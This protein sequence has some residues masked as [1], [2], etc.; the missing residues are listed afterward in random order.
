ML[1]LRP[2][3][4]R[5]LAIGLLVPVILAL[6]VVQGCSTNSSRLATEDLVLH[7]VA[8]RY[9]DRLVV[10]ATLNPVGDPETRIELSESDRL[11]VRLNDQAGQLSQQWNRVYSHQLQ[12]EEG[13]LTLSLKR[14]NGH[15]QALDTRL[16]LPVSPEFQAPD[17]DAIFQ[18]ARNS[19]IPV[20]WTGM[21]TENGRFDLMCPSARDGLRRSTGQF[22]VADQ[23]L[24][25]HLD[26]LFREQGWPQ[27]QQLCQLE[28]KLTGFSS[29]G[30]L[31]SELGGGDMLFES[32]VTRTVLIR[33]NALF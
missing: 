17:A 32:H 10:H 24:S 21:P 19:E 26:E 1:R 8:M 23:S 27:R 14:D 16:H 5:R 2:V 4:T 33:H 25:I 6:F 30:K 12:Y 3:P 22:P 28:L 18:T 9:N 7:L 31:S 20:A 29:K 13:F 11:E 15:T